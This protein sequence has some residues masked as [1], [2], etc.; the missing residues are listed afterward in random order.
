[1][2]ANRDLRKSYE[3]LLADEIGRAD[4]ALVAGEDFDATVRD[5]R[6]LVIAVFV[7]G[8]AVAVL[9]ALLVARMIVVPLRRVSGVLEA[10]ADGDL[11]RD[12]DVEQRDEVGRM[13]QSLRRATTT[14]RQT[15]SDLA[16]HSTR[17][18]AAAGSLAATSRESTGSAEAG[19]RQ[20][21][22]VAESAATMSATIQT[23]AA[24]AAT[25]G[26]QVAAT[27]T[28]VAASVQL[29]TVGVGAANR[30]AGQLAEMSGDLRAIVDRFTL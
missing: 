29:T 22:T 7:I 8:A 17:L 23:V 28:D 2:G 27:I 14:L 16:S 21:A 18:G 12:A 19:A 6:T 5:I 30:A 13:A 26:G 11:S 24:G 3:T 1:M 9:L 10:V 25:P 15:V 4:D 20:A